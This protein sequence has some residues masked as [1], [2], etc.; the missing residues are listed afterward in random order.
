MQA[1]GPTVVQLDPKWYDYLI[2]I[3]GVWILSLTLQPPFR[4]ER[5]LRSTEN[6]RLPRRL[7]LRISKGIRRV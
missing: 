4:P 1:D 3:A 6:E 7:L 5:V 2:R